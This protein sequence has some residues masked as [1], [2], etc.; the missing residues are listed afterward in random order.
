MVEGPVRSRIDYCESST[1]DQSA[2]T[3]VC[4]WAS[5]NIWAPAYNAGIVQPSNT[6][7]DLSNGFSKGLARDPFLTRFTR[8]EEQP[9]PVGTTEW[10]AQTASGGIGGLVPYVIAGKMTGGLMRSGANALALEGVSARFAASELTASVLG[11]VAYDGLRTPQ[12]HETRLGNMAGGGAAFTVF[13]V[14]N[15]LTRSLPLLDRIVVGGFVGAEGAKLQL[16]TSE[17]ISRGELP[18]ESELGQAALSGAFMNIALPHLQHKLSSAVDVVNVKLGRGIPVERFAAEHGMSGSPTLEHLIRANPLTRVH[19]D[20]TAEP[21]VDH[22]RNRTVLKEPIA[23]L[24][25]HEL[26]HRKART[27]PEHEAVFTRAGELLAAGD[28]AGAWESYRSARAAQ[29]QYAL[30]AQRKVATELDPRR[31]PSTDLAR[32]PL[33]SSGADG[34]LQVWEQEFLKFE[35]SRGRFRP[36]VDFA[37]VDDNWVKPSLDTDRSRALR[38]N[39]KLLRS[40]PEETLAKLD[41]T[42]VELSLKECNAKITVIYEQSEPIVRESGT[43][44]PFSDYASFKRD[45]LV[46]K[47]EQCHVYTLKGHEHLRVVVPLEYSNQLHE[48]RQLRLAAAGESVTQT[49]G[50]VITQEQAKAKLDAHKL[51]DRVM[52]EELVQYLDELPDSRYFQRI[53][54]SGDANPE[55]VWVRQRDPKAASSMATDGSKNLLMFQS[56]H[57]SH[58]RSDIGHE[59]VHRLADAAPAEFEAFMDACDLEYRGWGYLPAHRTYALLNYDEHWAVTGEE[60][61]RTDRNRFISVAQRAPLR[62]MVLLNGVSDA[63]NLSTVDG[64]PGKFSDAYRAR[65]DFV[66]EHVV[67]N[68]WVDLHDF[69][70]VSDAAKLRRINVKAYLGKHGLVDPLTDIPPEP[71]VKP[72][73]EREPTDLVEPGPGHGNETSPPKS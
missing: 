7:I 24:L 44:G 1:S 38:G 32:E 36:V 49:D 46:T 14:G 54:L 64:R 6:L 23:E 73:D 31:S 30:A 59:W 42:P 15:S 19:V 39:W 27:M 10:Y 66:K 56:R 5:Q 51:K 47:N 68:G 26:A 35:S 22:V 41:I 63:L 52:P 3:R 69:N 40:L 21:H 50:S 4:E 65:I 43:M 60:L 61:L 11:A 53:V 25:A 12:G 2:S 17:L 57:S 9:A 28:R 70:I 37:V 62:T 72:V 13:S 33:V 55:D 20:A 29:E 18:S 45:G 16:A 34:H 71:K 48:V 58:L 8:Q 67:P